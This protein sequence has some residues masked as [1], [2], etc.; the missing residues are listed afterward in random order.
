MMEVSSENNVNVEN[1]NIDVEVVDDE[2]DIQVNLP[3][4]STKDVPSPKHKFLRLPLARVKAMMKMD[5]DCKM[6]SH[7]S[8]FL[9]TKATEMFID[10]LAKEAGNQLATGKRKTVMKR[11]VDTA[12]GAIPNLCFLEGALD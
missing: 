7:D 6:I 3:A 8:I 4:S 9:V 12:V 1:L 10:F 5:P 2:A 11:D